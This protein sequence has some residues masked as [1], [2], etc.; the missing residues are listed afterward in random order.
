M[1]IEDRL[2]FGE[3]PLGGAQPELEP[4]EPIEEEKKSNRAFVFIAIA[5]GGLIVLGV[6]ALVGAL[7]FWLPRQEAQQAAMVTQTVMSMT[8]EA[9]AWTPT[10]TPSPTAQPATATATSV[11][12][13]TPVPTPTSTRVVSAQKLTAQP[14]ASPTTAKSAEWGG[15]GTTT[16][17]AGLGGFGL[18][19][20]AVGLAG[21]VFAVR[22]L[23]S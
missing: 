3:G 4:E 1:S 13:E 9:A 18:T 11:P 6:L 17:S 15:S 5:M 19:A 14:T 12:T 10:F 20:I 16:P 21:L 8:E 7:T 22:K 23:R 2:S